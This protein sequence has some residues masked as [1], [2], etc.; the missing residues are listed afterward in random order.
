MTSTVVRLEAKTDARLREMTG[1]E[2][3]S[4]DERVADLLERYQLE[5]FR[6]RV[7]ALLVKLKAYATAWRTY[8]DAFDQSLA[9]VPG[10]G[11]IVIYPLNTCCGG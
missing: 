4:M 6:N 9:L 10:G 5:L 7:D 3:W 8:Q 1:V 2:R 11:M